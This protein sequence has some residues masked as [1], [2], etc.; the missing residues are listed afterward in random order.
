MKT[1]A[2]WQAIVSR[3]QS[4]AQP[5]YYG[6]LTTGIFCVPGCPAR[7]PKR[8]NVVY[9]DSIDDAKQAG[10]RPC[11]RCQP[12][13]NSK[14]QQR[15]AQIIKACRLLDSAQEKLALAELASAVGLSPYHFQREFKK[16]VGITPL[17][18]S[19]GVRTARL[20]QF[21]RDNKQ[22]TEAIY[23]SGYES[24]TSAYQDNALA[25]SP[26]IYR[27][28]GRG[29][30][31]QFSIQK[32]KFDYVVIGVTE[33]GICAIHMAD[34]EAEAETTLRERFPNANIER[35]EAE[36]DSLIKAT[37]AYIEGPDTTCELPLDIQGTAFQ[38]Q[39][40][41][42][43]RSIRPGDTMTYSEVAEKLGKPSA[44]RAVA[45]AC[46][47]NKLAV[48]IPCH[49]VVGKSGKLTGYRWGIERKRA[50]LANEKKSSE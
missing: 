40:W 42:V 20:E 46:A 23:A 41:Q 43:L 29:V 17:Q 4:G 33:R 28:G 16:F 32:S 3:T 19:R 39:V 47:N 24:S 30:N 49:R 22:V 44:F 37:V 50:L 27:A 1:D 5:F 21:L 6:V 14:R 8:D 34:T 45:S 38:Q 25:M 12:E 15:I 48:V 26:K 18:Y 2:R 35:A 36:L 31:I 9:F 11:K 7:Q 13:G 10:Y